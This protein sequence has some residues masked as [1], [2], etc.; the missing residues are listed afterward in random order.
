MSGTYAT[1][2]LVSMAVGAMA[3]VQGGWMAITARRPSWV[4]L[5]LVP[6]GRERAWGVALG[7][8]GLSCVLLGASIIETVAFSGLRLVGIGLLVIGVLVLVLASRPQPTQ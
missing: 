6:D 3:M 5:R 2:G 4:R 1:I 7:A 8:I